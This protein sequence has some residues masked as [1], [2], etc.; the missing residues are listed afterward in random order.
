MSNFRRATLAGAIALAA[1]ACT[2]FSKQPVTAPASPAAT[3]AAL[4]LENP[5]AGRARF[6]VFNG[7]RVDG[8]YRPRAYAIKLFLNG[9]QIGEMNRREAMVF[10]VAPG[11]YALHWT[12]LHGK[13][14]AERLEPG[15]FVVK[16][17]ELLVLQADFDDW[18]LKMNKGFGRG[19]TTRDASTGREQ[20]D[21]DVE[22]VR[23][24]S[25]PPTVCL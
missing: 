10:D 22:L 19:Q 25:C 20:I 3:Q 9:A 16:S 1:A 23:P 7:A 24:T 5:P 8:E 12:S 4:K 21:P 13:A 17:G 15:T 14:L 11:Q 18:V 6:I 2:D